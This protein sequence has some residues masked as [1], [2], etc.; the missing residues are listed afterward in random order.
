VHADSL[1]CTRKSLVEARFSYVGPETIDSL[2]TGS[3]VDREQVWPQAN[4]FA[5]PNMRTVKGQMPR[6]LPGIVGKI[7]I[8]ELG[9]ERPGVLC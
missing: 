8:G 2:Q 1:G 6:A 3:R 9:E 4:V 7:D 5:V